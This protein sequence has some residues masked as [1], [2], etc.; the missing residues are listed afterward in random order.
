M[1]AKD[2]EREKP[3]KM[4]QKKIQQKKIHGLE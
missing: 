3:A 4:E 2:K 1:V